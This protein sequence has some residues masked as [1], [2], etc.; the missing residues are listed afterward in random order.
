MIHT[1]EKVTQ[2]VTKNL[3]C[4]TCGKKVRRS[5]TICN[6]VN[7]FNRNADDEIKS[8]TEVRQDVLDQAVEW[9]TTPEVCTSCK[10]D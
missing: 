10:G 6:T 8:W 7:P 4:P 5:T 1:Y 9:R 3:P 2:R